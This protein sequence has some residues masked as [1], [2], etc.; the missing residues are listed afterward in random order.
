MAPDLPGIPRRHAREPDLAAEQAAREEAERLTRATQHVA[1]P[2]KEVRIERGEDPVPSSN[3]WSMFPAAEAA[4]AKVS[5]SVLLILGVGAGC[6]W[7]G[8]T[9]HQEKLQ[10]LAVKVQELKTAQDSCA[11][12]TRIEELM[13]NLTRE[14]AVMSGRVQQTNQDVAVLSQLIGVPRR[15]AAAVTDAKPDVE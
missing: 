6:Y 7:A 9:R 10:E 14:Q 4:K 12:A 5:V 15:R 2:P 13:T 8:S 3:P 11:R 1:P